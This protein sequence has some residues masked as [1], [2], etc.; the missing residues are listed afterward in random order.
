M[1][2][3][4]TRT[5]LPRTKAAYA[6]A[7]ADRSARP[8][9]ALLDAVGGGGRGEGGEGGGKE[10]EEGDMCKM[11]LQRMVAEEEEEEEG[12]EG[13]LKQGGGMSGN[14]LQPGHDAARAD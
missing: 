3:Q 2:N 11:A 9:L 1:M 4:R 14:V 10:E 8:L 6:Q 5:W 12:G 7:R 13:R